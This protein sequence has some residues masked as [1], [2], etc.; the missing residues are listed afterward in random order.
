MRITPILIS[1]AQ[2]DH[3]DL[4]A[5]LYELA[6]EQLEDALIA[7]GAHLHL[8][9]ANGSDKSGDGNRAAREHLNNEGIPT[10]DR[11]LKSKGL[12]HNK[13]LVLSDAKGPAAVWTGTLIGA[14][15]GCARRSTTGC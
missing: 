11:L 5:A 15:P 3:A 6:D 13:F 1:Q 10:I 7:I 4:Y 8:I 14:R 2:D 9:L 12:G